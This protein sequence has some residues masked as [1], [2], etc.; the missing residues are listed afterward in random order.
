MP[1]FDVLEPAIDPN[2]RISFLLDW[3]LTMKCNLDCSYCLQE[4]HGGHDNSTKHPP[5]AECLK[6]LNFMFEYVDQYM[7]YKPKGLKTVILNIYGGES[8][9]HPDI[10]KILSEVRNQYYPYKDRWQLTVTTTTNAIISSKKLLN[11][12]PYIDE[13]TTSYHTETT[14]KQKQQFKDNLL[15]IQA[16]GIRLKCIV[17]MYDIEEYFADAEL[18]I[19][20][21]ADNNIKLLPRQLDDLTSK[22]NNYNQKQ[23][24]WFNNLHQSKTYGTSDKITP[25]NEIKLNLSDT[26]RACCGGRQTCQDQNYQERKFYVMDNKFTGWYC[27]VNWFFLYIKQVNGEVY[28]NKDCK[29]N[30]NGEI[31]PIGNLSNTSEIL[32]TLVEQLET[33]T[34]S[35]I[36]C[37]KP[38]CYCGLCAPK[39]R[40]ITTYNQIITKYQKD[41]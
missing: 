4:L 11:I 34:L 23:V 33:K 41:Y 38:T 36:Q 28:V 18:M 39:A 6:T 24:Q 13:F 32:N 3:E 31:G 10:V 5:L 19:E 21:L 27:S 7:K 1:S 14:V 17:L 40:D 22:R 20:W 8:L 37:K 12:M 15:T 35:V 2:N 16:A 25:D 29:M 30:F 9:Y 26:G